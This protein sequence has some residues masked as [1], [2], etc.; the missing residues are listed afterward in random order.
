MPTTR[1]VLPQHL[2][3]A[4]LL[5]NP[6]LTHQAIADTMGVCKTTV[7][8]VSQM[9]RKASESGLMEIESYKMLLRERVPV[10]LRVDA[11]R[12][13]V[14]KSDTNPFAALKA[15]EYADSILGLGPKQQVA[16]VQ[17]TSR[18]M[19][20]LPAGTH[21]SVSIDTPDVTDITPDAD[22]PGSEYALG[23]KR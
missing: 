9:L 2:M 13:A 3:I 6:T 14:D 22:A 5:A 7:D 18:P 15:I 16:E 1:S 8:R 19:F 20:V 10:D 4:A 17:D 21:I 11:L 23:L 12:Q